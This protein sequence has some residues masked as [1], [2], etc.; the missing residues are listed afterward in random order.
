M[1]QHTESQAR[2]AAVAAGHGPSYATLAEISAYRRVQGIRRS[3]A[4]GAHGDR[5]TK[6]QRDRGAAKRAAIKEGT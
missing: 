3:G 6:R 2:A 1:D 5:R 4:A